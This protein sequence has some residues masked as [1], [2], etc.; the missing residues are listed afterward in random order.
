MCQRVSSGVEITCAATTPSERLQSLSRRDAIAMIGAASGAIA[1]GYSTVAKAAS[2][3][4]ATAVEEVKPGEDVFAYVSRVKG[5][6]DQSLYQQMIG[7]ANDFKEGDQ[8]IGVGAADE[9]TRNECP[10]PA[11]EHEDPRSP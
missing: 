3:R 11:G 8:A 7:A 10:R 4:S 6:F 9:A 2:D 1:T 5:S